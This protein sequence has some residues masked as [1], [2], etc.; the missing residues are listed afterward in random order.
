MAQ[1][2]DSK[3]RQLKRQEKTFIPSSSPNG[4]YLPEKA[5]AY[6]LTSCHQLTQITRSA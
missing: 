2:E 3:I 4:Y 6:D 5:G 1:I